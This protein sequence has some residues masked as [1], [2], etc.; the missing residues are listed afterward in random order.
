MKTHT[1]VLFGGIVT[2]L[3]IIGCANKDDALGV[4]GKSIDKKA[5]QALSIQGAP[6]WVLNGGQGD[7]SAVGIADII[8]GD[9]GY[10]RTEALALARDELARQV[11]T[12]VEGVINRAASVTMGSSVQ[13]AQ[14]S[15]ASEQIIK[16]GVSQTL[17]GTKQT[18]TWI[19]KDATK[20]F[21]LIK[22]NP[23]LKAKLQANVKREIN[24]SSLPSNIRQE[25]ARSFLIR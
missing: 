20:I 25:A 16:Q 17:S 19:T 11:A 23:E 15:K 18:D 1:K 22:L 8:N 2:G 9:L 21:V 3:L 14:V 7:M 4:G 6:N 13:D 24:K 12:E 5:L 10:A